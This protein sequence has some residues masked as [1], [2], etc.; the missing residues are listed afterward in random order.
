MSGGVDSSAALALLKNKYEI[1]GAT[2]KLF[3]GSPQ[4]AE[5]AAAVAEKFGVVH[6]IF[7]M[8]KL[9]KEKVLDDFVET[10][11]SGGTPNP[12]IQCNKYVKFGALL[13]EAIRLGCEYYATG[14]YARVEYDEKSGRYLLKKALLQSGEISPKDQSYVLY[15]L[16][17]EQ[18]KHIVLPLGCME[19]EQVRKIAESAGLINSNKPDSQDICFVPDG[20]YASFIKSYT[21]VQPEAGSF[22]NSDGEILGCHKGLIHYTIGQRKGLGISFGKPMFVIGKNTQDNTVVLGE[23]EQL[24]QSSLTAKDVNFIS[25]D[26]LSAPLNCKAKTRYT[27]KEQP[28]VIS[29]LP[30][31]RVLVEFMQ[32]QRAITK[33]Q[34]VVFYDEDIVIGGGIIE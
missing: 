26:K 9:F 8:H 25:I 12:C 4:D 3:D 17:Q 27:Q 1:I 7:E 34:S 18:L 6:H 14:H 33:G 22:I 10:Y 20:D 15:N 5:D 32:P 31:G 2:L 13:D 24:M 11:L 21:G 28:C 19:K 30:D 23:G 16:T 29:P